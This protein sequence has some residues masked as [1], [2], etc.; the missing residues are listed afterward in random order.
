[1]QLIYPLKT[2]CIFLKNLFICIFIILKQ[3]LS[4]NNYHGITGILE[5]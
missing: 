2:S 1:M 5:D 3:S 4:Y